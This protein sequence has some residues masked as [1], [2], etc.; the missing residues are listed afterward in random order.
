VP[1]LIG[2]TPAQAATALH[3]AG[4]VLGTISYAVD[5]TCNDIGRVKSQNPPAGRVVYFS[6]AVSVTIGE[7]PPAPF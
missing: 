1:K 2:D 7:L 3:S 4:L 5:Y 6:S